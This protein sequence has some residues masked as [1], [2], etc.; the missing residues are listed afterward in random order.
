VPRATLKNNAPK[1]FNV[2]LGAL[3]LRALALRQTLHYFGA[4]FFNVGLGH[5]ALRQHCTTSGHYFSMLPSGIWPSDNTAQLRGIIF[6]CFPRAFG[7]QTTRHNFGASF[8]NVSLAPVS[9]WIS[10]YTSEH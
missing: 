2:A 6:Q 7:P 8:F 5:L 9:T 1:L 3:A 10:Q 4:L